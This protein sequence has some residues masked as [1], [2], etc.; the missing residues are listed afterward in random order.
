M[1]YGE[2]LSAAIVRARKKHE[3]ADC[4]RNIEPGKQYHRS[5]GT[6]DGEFY[7]VKRCRTCIAALQADVDESDDACNVYDGDARAR[8]RGE[9]WRWTLARLRGAWK[10]L[11]EGPQ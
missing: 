8:L 7:A 2:T 4:G 1:C 9:P 6:F 3:C 5:S 10:L 11:R